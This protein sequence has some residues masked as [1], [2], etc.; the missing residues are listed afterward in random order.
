[1][2]QYGAMPMAGVAAPLRIMAEM[3]DDA[4]ISGQEI[5]IM[6]A[7]LAKAFDTCEYWSQALSW[8]CLGVPE[9]MINLLVNLDS[10][11]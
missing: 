4:R 5:H 7:D 3:M 1:M 11:N 10:G 2:G 8:K 6:V 9:E